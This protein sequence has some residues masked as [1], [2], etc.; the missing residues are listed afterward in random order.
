MW[1]VVSDWVPCVDVKINICKHYES[2]SFI[3]DGLVFEIIY[4]N[5][6]DALVLLISHKFINSIVSIGIG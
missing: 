1:Q 6:S 4:C 5:V 2:F 3:A